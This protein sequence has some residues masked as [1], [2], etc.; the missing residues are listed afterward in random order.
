MAIT[1]TL[2]DI[3]HG[4]EDKAW[5][6]ADFLE[7]KGI[8]IASFCQDKG[9]SPIFVFGGVLIAIILILALVS[10]AGGGGENAVLI[11]QLSDESGNPISANF[12]VTLA[13]GVEKSGKSGLDGKE[14]ID[15]LPYGKLTITIT[16]PKYKGQ[17]TVT[18]SKAEQELDMTAETVK[19]TLRV[20]VKNTAGGY[21]NT[22][23]VDIKDYTTSSVVATSKVDGSAQYE[24]TVPVGVYRVV[25]KSTSGGEL[26]TEIKEIK[27]E[28]AYEV[29]FTVS[30]DAANSASVTIIVK[31]ENGNIM[32][33]VHVI[34]RNGRNDAAIGDEQVTDSSGQT[35][36]GNIAMGTSVYPIAFVANDKRYGQ[37]TEYDS[38]S[39]YK[40]TVDQLLETMNVVLPLNGRVEVVVWDKESMAYIS[41]ASVAI[42]D[43][44][45][46]VLST[47]KQTDS[48]GLA[49]FTG[50]EENVEVYPTVTALGFSDYENP[51]DARPITYSQATRFTV[52]LERDGSYVRSV[53]TVLPADTYGDAIIDLDAVL[54]EVGGAFIRG[55]NG[56]DNVS[57]EVDATKLY[58]VALY[59]PGYLRALLEG[60]GP[61]MHDVTMNAAN[62]VN[63]GDV[64]V[65]A[66][67]MIN[68]EP[69]EATA[70]VDLYLS[71]G[72]LIGKGNTIGGSDGDNCVTFADVPQEWSVYAIAS[73][74][75]YDPIETQITEVVPKEDGYTL[76]NITFN[77]L[78]QNAAATGDIKVCVANSGNN[79]V[80]GAEV[81][82]YDTDLDAPSWTG[83]YR[84]STASDGCVIFSGL[85]TEKTNFEGVL[86][87]V[88]VYPI[89]SAS[90]YATYNGKTDGNLV[91]VQPARMTP[92]NVRLG[93]G[94]EICITVKSNG[95][96]LAGAGVSLCAN[97]PCTEILETKSAESD[98]H[99]IF[100]SDVTSI[101]VKVVGNVDSL[102]KEAISSFALSQVT[103]GLCGE[104]DIQEI[105]QYATVTLDG[106]E[107]LIEV[108]P[109]TSAE[110]EFIVRVNSDVA[111]GGAMPTGGQ[112]DVLAADGTTKVLLSLT[113]DI[114]PGTVRDVDAANGKYALPF[115]SPA[116]YGLHSATL[117]ASIP[118]CETCQGAQAYITISVG[119]GDEDGDGVSDEYDNCPGSL[120]GTAVD[121][122]G[123]PTISSTDSD[124]D[125]IPDSSDQCGGTLSGVQVDS[126][127]CEIS[128]LVDSDGDGY[129][130]AYDAYPND[131]TQWYPS[132]T[133]GTTTTGTT[134]TTAQ[135]YQSSVQVCVVD[136]L[137]A[138]VYDSSITMYH[139]GVAGAT[140]TTGLATGYTGASTG[141]YGNT[142]QAWQSVYSY[143][144]CRT[145]MGYS[146]MQNMALSSFMS[147][148]YLGVNA[149]GYDPYDSRGGATNSIRLGSAS[150]A[151]VFTLE[152]ILKRGKGAKIGQ[153]SIVDPAREVLLKSATWKVEQQG[154]KDTTSIHPLVTSIDKNV[155]I[156]V[157]YGIGGGA[158]DTLDYSVTYTITGNACYEIERSS[159]PTALG[160]NSPQATLHFKKGQESVEDE[161]IIYTKDNCWQKNEP[162]LETEFTMMMEGRLIQIGDRESTSKTA[163]TP[164]KVTVKPVIGATKEV[165]STSQLTTLNNMMELQYGVVTIGTVPYCIDEAF[166]TGKSRAVSARGV[167]D[168][169]AADQKIVLEFKGTN[170]FPTTLDEMVKQ[171]NDYIR[172]RIRKSPLDCKAYITVYDKYKGYVEV[173]QKGF[174]CADAKVQV[175]AKQVEPWQKLFCDV[176][177]S[178]VPSQIQ[179]GGTYSMKVDSK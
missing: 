140:G 14:T 163:F 16:E 71:T 143:D 115:V 8:P 147:S 116:T 151:G 93:A 42:K 63:V 10:G 48:Q 137:G 91:Q 1:D 109:S 22:G 27:A 28:E 171:I 101:T 26:K 74:D 99:V 144:N 134:A 166:N 46:D 18:I 156:A 52:S 40:T 6:L 103:L 79:P 96:P 5:S 19:G 90:G 129:P 121:S 51:Q 160:N 100:S 31:D 164:A 30:E 65:C 145:F 94:Q 125:G 110:I 20:I 25:L 43:K 67:M 23:S 12:K 112:N 175:G 75:A 168:R 178:G 83:T 114:V 161:L 92:L 58:N 69:S 138:P 81:L 98:G 131:A 105:D 87:P 177:E 61:G 57:F 157:K 170:A 35:V 37:L 77:Q 111:S 167:S 88:M 172:G 84:L 44:A 59:K 82:L 56:T 45:G 86:T 54:S 155:N 127:G 126:T 38:K 119:G 135:Q 66:Y 113:G 124:G 141:G 11:V 150:Q 179:L 158:S 72:A 32:P 159:G 133:T 49:S 97:A 50:F 73:S 120:N 15:K 130:D 9:V 70:A 107:G 102:L 80:T 123:C 13:S 95:E 7:D 118:T 169:T 162:A 106:I 146:S 176:V 41:G 4:L 24:F 154:K 148:F 174:S 128:E 132:T 139:T 85:P 152:I 53:I 78:L 173:G 108:A 2:A 153:G 64:R 34:L 136:D 29:S 149:N 33:N 36:F 89:V 17:E 76:I 3:W 62:T 68:E 142:G 122:Y 117:A 60:V 104:V 55:L 47:T 39:K 165:K 21:I